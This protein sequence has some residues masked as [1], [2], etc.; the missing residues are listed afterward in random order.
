MPCC[1][2]IFEWPTITFRIMSKL[3]NMVCWSHNLM[4]SFFSDLI[5]CLSCLHSLIHPQYHALSK[6]H[7]AWL[8]PDFCM[9]AK[10]SSLLFPFLV[11]SNS[12]FQFEFRYTFLFRSICDHTV[13]WDM[14][15]CSCITLK[16][17]S[18][19]FVHS[20]V[21]HMFLFYLLIDCKLLQRQWLIAWHIKVSLS[22]F[23]LSL[24]ISTESQMYIK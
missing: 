13:C 21:I 9:C 7:Y 19:H 2:L 1:T 3:L 18:E 22:V 14:S 15:M 20:I 10:H 11:N 12:S 17:P 16:S 8:F 6:M 24:S 23:S 5:S 4:L